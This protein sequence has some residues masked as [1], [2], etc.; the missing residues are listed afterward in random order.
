MTFSW[1]RGPV[2]LAGHNLVALGRRSASEAPLIAGFWMRL[3]ALEREPLAYAGFAGT[4]G[5]LRGEGEDIGDWAAL[6]RLLAHLAEP[7]RPD[8]Q[9]REE[10]SAP[11]PGAALELARQHHAPE[12]GRLLLARDVIPTV[13]DTGLGFRPVT[14]AGFIGLQAI[15]AVA[16]PEPRGF[17]RCR[18]CH[19]WYVRSRS[20]Q[21]FCVPAHR[22][23]AHKHGD[24]EIP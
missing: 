3:A 17:H 22:F 10:L 8:Q 24:K 11:P 2:R 18:W 15:A 9:G 19:Q 1:T 12:L 23:L 5:F 4:Y 7:W 14:L 21:L 13:G 6:T 20:D 16:A